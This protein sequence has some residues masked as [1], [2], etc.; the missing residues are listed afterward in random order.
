V[1]GVLG[2]FPV[3]FMSIQILP[4][5]ECPKRSSLQAIHVKRADA[6]GIRVS[7]TPKRTSALKPVEPRILDRPY[8]QS[9]W[10]PEQA[11]L[12][13][14]SSREHIAAVKDVAALNRGHAGP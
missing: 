9:P 1:I 7:V 14:S 12:R 6:V 4:R 2:R 8:E 11:R 5:G 13:R 3:L 10:L